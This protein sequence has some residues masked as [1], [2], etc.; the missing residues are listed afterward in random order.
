MSEI[1]WSKA[2]EGAN[3]YQ[4]AATP[5]NRPVF[6]RVEGD[7]AREVWAM[8]PDGSIRDHFNYGPDGCQ[9]FA[10]WRC[11]VKPVE[12]KGEGLPPV[13]LE[14]ECTYDAWGYWLKG[15]VLCYG[16]KMIFM[17]QE[18]S[19]GDG[20]F[21]G[22]MNPDGIRFRPICTPEQIAA[23]E[24]AKAIDEMWSVYWQPDVTTAKEALGL[25]YDAGYRKPEAQ[26]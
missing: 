6:W 19:K 5:N 7:V 10:P 13:G 2:P 1:D 4:P 16:E 20:K 25:L 9:A 18:S 15:K 26:P 23:D 11:I 3:H 21:E 22:S 12:W 14:I 24:R 17:E 8:N